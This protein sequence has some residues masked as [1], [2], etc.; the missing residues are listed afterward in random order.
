M[1]VGSVDRRIR[2]RVYGGHN[3][4]ILTAHDKTHLGRQH[5]IRFFLHV[6][7]YCAMKWQYVVHREDRPRGQ[8]DLLFLF[9]V[10]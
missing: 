5:G 9:V 2:A 8:Q 6:D 7:D 10:L 4:D 3:C 1:C